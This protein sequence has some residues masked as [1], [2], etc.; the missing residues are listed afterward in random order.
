MENMSPLHGKELFRLARK[1]SPHVAFFLPRNQDLCEVADLVNRVTPTTRR[2]TNSSTNPSSL[3]NL[4]TMCTTTTSGSNSDELHGEDRNTYAGG[5][6]D[7]GIGVSRRNGKINTP[8]G[9]QNDRSIRS[10]DIGN[11]AIAIEEGQEP[12]GQEEKEARTGRD[13]REIMDVEMVEVEEEWMGNKLK[14][15]T[16]YFGGLAKGQEHLWI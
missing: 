12:E 6:G 11:R 3:K 7:K 16:C 5:N 4:Q 1:I 9:N 15:L 8:N 2:T 13:E 14:A 10:G